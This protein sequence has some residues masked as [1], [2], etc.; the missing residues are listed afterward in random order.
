MLRNFGQ[1]FV[2]M[3]F[4]NETKRNSKRNGPFRNFSKKFWKIFDYFV[5]EIFPNKFWS[6]SIVDPTIEIFRNLFRSISI[7][8]LTIEIFRNFFEKFQSL[9]KFRCQFRSEKRSKL[10]EILTG[11]KRNWSKSISK[12]FDRNEM[13]H[14]DQFRNILILIP[15]PISKAVMP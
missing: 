15:E 14:F 6:I 1:C 11:S 4:Q 12:N 8:D 10:I 2:S 3:L 9:T 5:I 13:D 7:V